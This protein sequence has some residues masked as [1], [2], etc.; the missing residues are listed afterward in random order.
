MSSNDQESQA[1]AGSH[2]DV[3]AKGLFRINPPEDAAVWLTTGRAPE[4]DTIA[5]PPSTLPPVTA[6]SWLPIWANIPAEDS[7]AFGKSVITIPWLTI[8]PRHCETPTINRT[9]NGG[10]L[11]GRQPPH[12]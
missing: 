1:A 8:W 9:G 10:R 2:G 12:A 4:L 5:D 11:R 6:L 3:P 7:S